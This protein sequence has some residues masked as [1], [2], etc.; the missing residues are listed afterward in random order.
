CGRLVSMPRWSVPVRMEKGGIQIAR[1]FGIPILIHFSWVVVFAL[2]A[3]TLAT[4]YFPQKDPDLPEISYWA[5]GLVASL[6]FFLSILLHELGHSYV[7]MRSGLRIDSITLFIF[8]GV[9]RL[10]SDPKDGRTEF[11]MAAAG[12]LVSLVLAGLFYAASSASV[13]GGATRAV[14]RYL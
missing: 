12:P 11:R 3:W 13:L 8:G 9:A 5:R 6:L 2:I 1:V 10:G 7:A 4:G 14:S